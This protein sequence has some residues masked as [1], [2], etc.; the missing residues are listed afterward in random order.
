MR[1]ASQ[2]Q[3]PGTLSELSL[4]YLQIWLPINV[5]RKQEAELTDEWRTHQKNFDAAML[6]QGGALLP[7]AIADALRTL[8]YFKLAARRE[9]TE[10]DEIG[11]RDRS[12]RRKERI[13]T[14]DEDGDEEPD[15]DAY[16]E[17]LLWGRVPGERT[18]IRTWRIV[19]DG[20]ARHLQLLTNGEAAQMQHF[21]ENASFEEIERAHVWCAP[22]SSLCC[23]V[24]GVVHAEA[25]NSI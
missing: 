17:E 10:G 12:A 18:T 4:A 19:H 13:V 14:Y 7:Q 23:V 3:L 16:E 25:L 1:V 8:R 9:A 20:D 15:P 22:F 21:M 2:Q 6:V 24:V 5:A 11:D